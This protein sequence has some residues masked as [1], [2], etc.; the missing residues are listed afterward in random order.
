M[1]Y[2]TKTYG[3]EAF[4]RGERYSASADKRRFVT[5]DN[6]L[7]F[8]TDRI[9]DGRVKGWDISI[10]DSNSFSFSVSP[11]YGVIDRL[12]TQTFGPIDF[13]FTNNREAKVYIQRRL[14]FIGGFGTWSSLN[15]SAIIKYDDSLTAVIATPQNFSTQSVAY[16]RVSLQWDEN[17]T[18]PD[19]GSFVLYKSTDGS[20]YDQI[21][22]L[23][24]IQYEDFDVE[25]DTL[26]YYRIVA[27]DLSGNESAPQDLSIK[28]AKDLRV[29]LPASNLGIFPNDSSVQLFWTASP[30]GLLSH[31][32]IQVQELSGNLDPIGEVREV[33]IDASKDLAVIKN[34]KNEVRYRFSVTAVS[35]NNV[36]S[37]TIESL[38]VPRPNDGPEEIQDINIVWTKGLSPTELWLDLEWSLSEDPYLVPPAYYKI[39]LYENGERESLPIA[40]RDELETRIKLIPFPGIEGQED[41]NSGTNY[42]TIEI[43]TEY[44]IR[45]QTVDDA[46]LESNG[47]TTKSFAPTY[48][49][50]SQV[51]Q[52]TV[53]QNEDNDDLIVTWQNPSNEFLQS[54]FIRVTERENSPGTTE[55]DLIPRT[56]IGIAESY[57]L[58]GSLVTTENRY[59][60]YLQAVDRFGNESNTVAIVFASDVPLNTRPEVPKLQQVTPRDGAV[61]VSWQ[62]GKSFNTTGYR[63]YRADY[64]A[65]PEPEDFALLET[66]PKDRTEYIDYEVENDRRY[67]YFVT[68]IDNFFVE[69]LN[70][71]E[72]DFIG[73]PYLIAVP[74]S[75]NNLGQVIDVN[76]TQSGHDAVI[77]WTPTPGSYDGYE[78]WR[79]DGSKY[80]FQLVGNASV[81]DSSFTDEDALLVDGRNYYYLVR[82][83]LNEG[84]VFVTESNAPPAAAT[85]IGRISTLGTDIEIDTGNVTELELLK[86][87]IQKDTK[88][89]LDVHKHTISKQGNDRRIDLQSNATVINWRT[90]D[91]QNFYTDED[92]QGA[93]A[94]LVSTNGSVNEKFF[95]DD[96]G[97]LDRGLFEQVKQGLP[98]FL[99][100]VDA[101]EGRIT[102]AAPLFGDT[103]ITVFDP[104]A[105]IYRIVQDFLEENRRTDFSNLT[106]RLDRTY[107]AILS[108]RGQDTS[109]NIFQ[110]TLRPFIEEPSLS[111]TLVGIEEVKNILP[112]RRV[113]EISATQ[114]ESGV[115]PEAQLPPLLH[116]GRVKEPLVP[117]QVNLNSIDG[118]NFF[119]GKNELGKRER[120]QN[121]VTFY[122][123]V[124][125][126][127]FVREDKEEEAYTA[128][129]AAAKNGD[130][131][132]AATSQG[133]WVSD[134]FGSVWSNSNTKFLSPPTKLY[135]WEQEAKYLTLTNRG[136]YISSG[137]LKSWSK[138]RGL[139]NVR[140]TRDIAED[141]NGNLFLSTDLGVYRLLRT[142]VSQL[143]EWEQTSLFGPRSTESYAI[144]YD[145]FEDRM[146]VSNEFGI[147]QSTNTGL[148]WSFTDEFDE[149]RKIY[150][151]IRS[152]EYIFALTDDRIF[153]KKDGQNF[154]N[155]CLL[156][157][158][159]SRE[160]VVFNDRLFVSTNEG[161]FASDIDN[162]IYQDVNLLMRASLPEINVKNT[163]PP[164]TLLKNFEDFIFVGTDQRLFNVSNKIN[165]SVVYDHVLSSNNNEPPT[166]YVNGIEKKIG[167]YYSNN[168][169]STH[170][171]SFDE[172]IEFNDEATIAVD[173]QRF[174]LLSGGWAYQKFDADLDIYLNGI[175]T[176]TTRPK[177]EGEEDGDD[178]I[179]LSVDGE[180]EEAEAGE[181]ASEDQSA[182]EGNPYESVAKFETD[183]ENL[184]LYPPLIEETTSHPP[185]ARQYFQEA[186]DAMVALPEEYGGG[187]P[188]NITGGTQSDTDEQSEGSSGDDGPVDTRKTRPLITNALIALDK[189]ISQLYPS[190]RFH[191]FTD[192]KGREFTEPYELPRIIGRIPEVTWD[193]V[194]GVFEFE[195]SFSKFDD[196]NVDVFGVTFEGTA[197][198]HE[199]IEDGFEWKGSG[200]PYD[201]AT[202]MQSN[203]VKLGIFAEKKWPGQ[204][205]SSGGLYQSK[206]LVPR[207][208][209]LYDTFNS[210]VDFKERDY[211][212]DVSLSLP[213]ATSVAYVED[214]GLIFAGGKGG[215]LS[216]DVEDLKINNIKLPIE[217]TPYVKQVKYYRGTLYVLDSNK[218]FA[219]DDG[220]N[221]FYEI[222]RSGLPNEL[223]SLGILNTTLI[224][225]TKA[226]T[227]YKTPQMSRWLTAF[228]DETNEPIEIIHDPDLIFIVSD[229]SIYSSP[230]GIIYKK[231]GKNQGKQIN[232]FSKFRTITYAATDEGLQ[233]DSGSF[234]GEGARFSLINVLNNRSD[235]RDLIINHIDSN[236]EILVAGISDGR[237]IHLKDGLYTV[238]DDAPLQTI[239]KCIIADGKIWLFGYDSFAFIDDAILG[240]MSRA[241]RLS[242]GAP[243]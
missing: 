43:L 38:A 89:I 220:G 76:V 118:Y 155:I 107:N 194:R 119:I 2:V 237:F 95:E 28:T 170:S 123:I 139:E 103:L 126:A 19:F 13:S 49:A 88:E 96:N 146:I 72:D 3:L 99:Y 40:V 161:V 205:Q 45:I 199:L 163:R 154:V 189:F 92:I 240:N 184:K 50:P 231:T 158:D 206:F 81:S 112:S 225:G 10:K 156:D 73:Y 102:F 42:E 218:L 122:D 61:E 150:K 106:G 186:F 210:T 230:D 64:S 159:S 179:S 8:I 144:M 69:S 149:A 36:S 176:F 226:A 31:Y 7:A 98:P 125:V 202:P 62:L 138:M 55:V 17:T 67:I 187:N 209:Q 198:S 172:T 70:P 117:V 90:S 188:I 196:L 1:S 211:N 77:S 80:D 24:E 239:Q 243:L 165:V 65:R 66:L 185:L 60:F 34:L 166:I 238:Y 109:V 145:S 93:Q 217:T 12:V 142:S 169:D 167:V 164:A 213:Y 219:S 100:E 129:E 235:S 201:F 204:Q 25:Q 228:E 157:A 183:F 35:I 52:P 147:L 111:L 208:T 135:Y 127:D 6:Q 75:S 223:F 131:L 151:L 21:V 190:A 137:N 141:N 30:F 32:L 133:V 152:G 182:F 56:D 16:N 229:Q 224:V 14:N 181:V 101:D 171:V 51:V 214:E 58:P 86:T 121:S 29:P 26:Y 54:I 83:Y 136:V 128:L 22:E 193:A 37:E 108:L 140:V 221:S 87:P 27:K 74:K 47:I 44:Y 115:F 192:F 85:L 71:I 79:S 57:I 197:T 124:S 78:I 234:Y 5:I 116:D 130:A 33:N 134:D 222:V 113:E 4:T 195:S 53:V 18:N 15:N 120:I 232:A 104:E 233:Q 39:T 174:R 41:G 105:E 110:P 215:L 242:T 68:K 46:G 11:G 94:Y 91:W 175:K 23:K 241:I 177:P 114:V 143:L 132:V 153:R 227:Y 148:T 180:S 59:R 97:D 63:V 162:D 160:L 207:S 200:L 84:N 48:E 168:P 20:S 178:T 173:Y 191:T 9:G 82:R 203:V 236:D 212:K 216:I